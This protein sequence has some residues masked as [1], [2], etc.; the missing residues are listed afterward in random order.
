MIFRRGRKVNSVEL[1]QSEI[2]FLK[3]SGTSDFPDRRLLRIPPAFFWIIFRGAGAQCSPWKLEYNLSGKLFI[4]H[5]PCTS[6]SNI[7]KCFPGFPDRL[8]GRGCPPGD[9][10]SFPRCNG[11]RSIPPPLRLTMQQLGPRRLHTHS[12]DLDRRELFDIVAEIVAKALIESGAIKNLMNALR[13]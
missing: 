4:H 9:F 8:S 3:T 1:S 11:E 5:T 7:V 13:K 10:P 6:D 2:F 12:E